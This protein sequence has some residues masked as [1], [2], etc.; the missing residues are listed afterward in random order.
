MTA[1]RIR[2]GL[3]QYNVMPF[4]LANA[5]T[6]FQS[7]ID[8]ALT[9]MIDITAIVY[10]DDILIYFEKKNDHE[11]HVKKVLQALRDHGLFVKPEKCAFFTKTVEF[12][13]FIISPDEISMD[14]KRVTTI[15]D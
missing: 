13:G 12:L 1:F 4:E 6:T 8:R 14:P 3:Y 2:Y 10:L 9:K 15:M 7:Y 11:N 5:P